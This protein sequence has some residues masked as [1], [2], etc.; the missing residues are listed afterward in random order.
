[1]ILNALWTLFIVLFAFIA[2]VCYSVYRRRKILKPIPGLSEDFLIGSVRH[3]YNKPPREFFKI[4]VKGFQEFGKVWK[5]HL[6]HET[7]VFVADPK[8]LEVSDCILRLG[9]DF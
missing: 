7:I 5:V 9:S 3:F 1:M 2:S 8:I 4:F 6:L